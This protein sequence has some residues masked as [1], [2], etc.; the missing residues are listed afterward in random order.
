MM[1][2][3]FSGFS[4]LVMINYMKIQSY[5]IC[6]TFFHWVAIIAHVINYEK[7]N[8]EINVQLCDTRPNT[9][10]K[11]LNLAVIHPGGQAMLNR[12]TIA[13]LKKNFHCCQATT[14]A[15]FAV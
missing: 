9:S 4:R 12:I 14:S 3:R 10:P 11:K 5:G 2:R 7:L 13:W 1:E 6:K 8:N 15:T